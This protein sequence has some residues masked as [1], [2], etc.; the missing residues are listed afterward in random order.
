MPEM[1]DVEQYREQ[2]L[3]YTVSIL[4]EKAP[5]V[6]SKLPIFKKSYHSDFRYYSL[7]LSI[8]LTKVLGKMNVQ[9][10]VYGIPD[11]RDFPQAR[12]AWKSIESLA[13]LGVIGQSLVDAVCI[14]IIRHPCGY[15]SSVLHG[16]M[17]H[18]FQD[19]VPSS[20]DY[21]IFEQLLQ[22]GPAKQRGLTIEDVRSCTPLERM[23]W[24][25]VLYNEKALEDASG[26]P[27]YRMLNYDN[28]CSNTLEE[29]RELFASA[30]LDWSRQTEDFISS[31]MAGGNGAYYSVY[32]NPEISANKWKKQLDKEQVRQIMEVV[33]K[34]RFADVYGISDSE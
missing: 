11:G 9:M 17:K 19:S 7:H 26:L 5:K 27:G 8:L 33:E 4:S 2:I 32:K 30:G 22:T 3:E 24:R 1:K 23:A 20:E 21:G 25:W 15:I 18:N 14:H 10:P 31:S 34:S 13:R 29:A 28:F 12:L 6:C 16:E